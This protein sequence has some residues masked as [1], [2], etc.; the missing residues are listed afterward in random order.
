MM[1]AIVQMNR[2]SE[3]VLVNGSVHVG[4]AYRD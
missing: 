1:T 3:R 4:D 2:G